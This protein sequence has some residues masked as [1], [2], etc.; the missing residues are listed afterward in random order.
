MQSYKFDPQPYSQQIL[1]ILREIQA[2]KNWDKDALRKILAR[3]PK[4][5]RQIFSKDQLVMGYNYLREQKQFAVDQLLNERIKMKP[6]RTISGV[7]TVTVLTKPFP[8]PGK[9]I[10][11]PN[12]IR[13]PKSYLK[14]EPGA[15]RAERNAF[16]PYLQT[17]NRLLALKNIGHSTDKIELI[18]LG[19]TWSFY[20]DKYQIWF[21]KR[22]FEALN[23]FGVR[24]QRSLIKTTNLFAEADRIPNLTKEGRK[25]AYNELVT[26]VVRNHGVEFFSKEEFA[27][28]PELFVQHKLNEQA[29]SRCVGLV[30]ETRPDY[31]TEQEVIK[32][33]K[34]GA[35][36]IQIGVQS[37][38]DKIQKL[39][40]R[41]HG[42]KETAEAF[43]LL[44]LAGFK[45]HA[46]WMPGQYGA[47]V[48]AD[49]KD[50]QKL[51][52]KNYRPDELKIY[53]TSIIKNTELFE[54]YKRKSYVPYS[55]DQLLEV[56]STTMQNTPR[57]CRLTRVIRDIPSTDI[58]AG[59]KLTNFRQIAELKLKNE[60]KYCECIRC[61]EIKQLKI[62]AKDL[63]IE[64]IRYTTQVG[65]EIFISYRTKQSDK[66][67]G[68]LRLSLPDKTQSAVNFISEL[69]NAAI[70][71]EVHVYGQVV[72]IG[73]SKTG[74]AQHLGLGTKMIALAKQIAKQQTY[75][76][77]A[78]ISAI[79]TRQY[80]K[81][82]G[83]E[84][85]DLY[86]LCKI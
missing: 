74:K 32:L 79:G 75:Q 4:D 63:V 71:R 23:D 19:G 12:D 7:A 24:D 40:K 46:H 15:Q 44:R 52:S 53:P 66:I 30:I 35:T 20:P 31:I 27:D 86:M 38:N 56:L 77:I 57:Y 1:Q 54:L 18:V 2:T 72:D 49:I 41:G 16:D 50:Y 84:L 21:I 70:I 13:M 59:N 67:V 60:G 33:R 82:L 39:N 64:K 10:Y 9:C 65:K 3:Y 48:Q 76:K 58:I 11:C 37:L 5:G 78:V 73:E 42:K 25:R 8:C 62:A 68:F 26:S 17:Y 6:T 69:Q 80:Y 61:R 83:F 29:L 51:W 43:R 34:L 45:I 14:D 22:C 85:Q 28:F 81:K 36:K 55:Y 47:T